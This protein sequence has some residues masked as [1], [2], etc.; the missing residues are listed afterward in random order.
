M[1]KEGIAMDRKHES[2]RNHFSRHYDSPALYGMSKTSPYE[3]Y[4]TV[5]DVK[6]VTGLKAV[7]QVPFHPEEFL[8]SDLNFVNEQGEKILCIAF[9]KAGLY[10]TYR[11]TVPK[12][13]KTPVKD[14]GEEAFIGP[15]TEGR[16]PFM[17][18][19]RKGDH[20]V[21]LTT[22]ATMDAHRN[23]LTVDELIAIGVIIASR[24]E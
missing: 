15:D 11:S 1:F 23:L 3:K 9:S 8:G 7:W 24:L 20:A 19:F 18:V 22:A 21:S 14:L 4:L 17:L 12:Y 2:F 13:F 16:E 10:D 6:H 5:E